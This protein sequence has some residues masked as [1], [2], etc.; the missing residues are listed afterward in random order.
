MAKRKKKKKA[1]TTAEK[2]RALRL[3]SGMSQLALAQEAGL[4]R[5]TISRLELGGPRDLATLEKL[6]AVFEVTTAELL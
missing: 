4:N 2:V 6:A 1:E 3:E 5:V